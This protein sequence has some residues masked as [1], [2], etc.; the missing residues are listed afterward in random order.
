MKEKIK[1]ILRKTS[2]VLS[3][4]FGTGI[5]LSLFAGGLTFFGFL[6]RFFLQ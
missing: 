1:N 2:N 6:F 3:I 5:V 4:I